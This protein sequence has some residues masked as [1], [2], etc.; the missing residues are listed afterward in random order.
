MVSLS[1]YEKKGAAF[2]M[3][4]AMAV[5]HIGFGKTLRFIALTTSK[6]NWA[7]GGETSHILL[8]LMPGGFTCTRQVNRVPE[9]SLG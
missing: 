6:W 8:C 3:T 2:V 4:S 9:V 5:H 7:P 1:T